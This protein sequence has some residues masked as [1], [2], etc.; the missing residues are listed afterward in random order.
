MR[1]LSEPQF[2]VRA[3]I[4]SALGLAAVMTLFWWRVRGEDR[5]ARR[6]ALPGCV[7]RLGSEDACEERLDAHHRVCFNYNNQSA[8]RYS[9]RAFDAAGYLECVIQGPEPWAANRRA[10]RAARQ[11]AEGSTR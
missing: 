6:G 11:R 7:E 8:S 9:P 5:D 1:L 4:V 10:E 2:L 3:L